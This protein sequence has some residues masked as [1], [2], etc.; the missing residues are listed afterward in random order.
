[1]SLTS[2]WVQR[3]APQWQSG[4]TVLDVACGS[5]RHARDLAHRG[6]SVTGID[7]DAEALATLPAQV[8]R[9]QADLEGAPWPL[10]NQRFDI[11]IVTNYLWRPLWPTLIDTV[12]QGGWYI[13]ETFADGQ[14]HLGRPTN[15]AF[16]LQ[17]GE[18][19][20]ATQGL[21]VL[22]YEDGIVNGAR[23]QRV[24]ARRLCGASPLLESP[25]NP[26]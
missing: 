5:G 10:P 7:R 19:L 14:Q 25:V 6:L 2:P 3:W 20:R 11:V 24:A 16:L 21:H 18:L 1:M 13:H 22:A 4:Q 12:A 8:R 9:V 26:S 17:P 23:I 15:P